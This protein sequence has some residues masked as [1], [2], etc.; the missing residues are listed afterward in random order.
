MN[1]GSKQSQ[2]GD[3]L[4]DINGDCS[5]CWTIDDIHSGFAGGWH[6]GPSD[7]SP[8]N[9]ANRIQL[10]RFEEELTPFVCDQCE[11]ILFTGIHFQFNTAPAV[12]VTSYSTNLQFTGDYFQDDNSSSSGGA[13]IQINGVDIGDIGVDGSMASTTSYLF[14]IT[15]GTGLNP[16]YELNVT[17][18]NI[19]PSA[20]IINITTG[21][22]ENYAQNTGDYPVIKTGYSTPNLSTTGF[23]VNNASYNQGTYYYTT[24]ASSTAGSGTLTISGLS[25]VFNKYLCSGGDQTAPSTFVL[26]ATTS[27]SAVLNATTTVTNGDVIWFSCP[28]GN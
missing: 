16:V 11:N 20:G 2:Y 4:Q 7:G 27:T 6:M 23:S 14:A 10:G 13:E 25:P 19:H 22:L 5:D 21:Y 24:T 3:N 26:G 15:S 9:A 12:F 28:G 17:G 1:F 8:G 18:G